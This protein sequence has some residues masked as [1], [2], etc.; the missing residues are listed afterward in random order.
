MNG[1]RARRQLEPGKP[2]SHNFTQLQF[3]SAP[4]SPAVYLYVKAI[5]EV[6]YL[7]FIKILMYLYI[8]GTVEYT[9][10]AQASVAN[11]HMS[12]SNN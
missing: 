9:V 8:T 5:T 11:G 10:R 3:V 7:Q 2:L 6:H 1:S 4:T 12:T